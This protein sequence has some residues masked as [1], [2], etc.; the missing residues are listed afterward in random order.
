M[1]SEFKQMWTI[2][3]VSQQLG[4]SK[5][6]LRFWEKEFEDYFS[7]LR[8]TGGQRRYCQKHVSML[9]KIHEQKKDG[10][11]LSEIKHNL[12]TNAL[13][14]TTM[15]GLDVESLT[16]RIMTAVSKE[17]LNFF[18]ERNLLS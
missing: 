12:M 16:Q 10:L 4:L 5:S 18:K 13:Q 8:T 11:S 1:K 17:L 2:Q 14:Q 9:Q 3:E 7:P 15:D 6:T